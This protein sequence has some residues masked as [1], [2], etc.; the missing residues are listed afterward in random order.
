[1]SSYSQVNSL[2][3]ESSIATLESTLAQDAQLTQVVDAALASISKEQLQWEKHKENLKQTD[4]SHAQ[5]TKER[6]QLAQQPE[7]LH[8]MLSQLAQ[9]ADES[10]KSMTGLETSLTPPHLQV[11]RWASAKFRSCACY[12]LSLLTGGLGGTVICQIVFK[13]TLITVLGGG[14]GALAV[15]GT[16]YLIRTTNCCSRNC[17]INRL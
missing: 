17:C 16:V 10:D 4:A 7:E 13:N 14:V 8:G 5:M 3:L 1:M 11:A 9:S 2:S 6:I 12:T 15:T